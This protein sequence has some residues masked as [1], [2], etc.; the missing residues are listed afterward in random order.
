MAQ[1]VQH[2]PNQF[3]RE[4]TRRLAKVAFAWFMLVITAIGILLTF[5]DLFL[6]IAT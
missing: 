3:D 5:S 1:S 6:G 4:Q 2:D